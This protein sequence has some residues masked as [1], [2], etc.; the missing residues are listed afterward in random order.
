MKNILSILIV[1]GFSLA[2]CEDL[3]SEKILSETQL[4]GINHQLTFVAEVSDG[5]IFQHTKNFYANEKRDTNRRCEDPIA[6]KV[7]LLKTDFEGNSISEKELPTMLYQGSYFRKGNATF[8]YNNGTLIELDDFLNEKDK[9]TIDTKAITPEGFTFA[10][11]SVNNLAFRSKQDFSFVGVLEKYPNT[12][13]WVV[14]TIKN[15]VVT[16]SALSEDIPYWSGR[17]LSVMELPNGDLIFMTNFYDNKNQ[18]SLYYLYRY[19]AA[20]NEI[21]QEVILPT[22][23]YYEGT[24]FLSAD[25]SIMIFPSSSNQKGAYY[26]ILLYDHKTKELDKKALTTF[27]I[28]PNKYWNFTGNLQV[29]MLWQWED[30]RPLIYEIAADFSV[31]QYTSTLEDSRFFKAEHLGRWYFYTNEY[32]TQDNLETKLLW[33]TALH[34]N[35]SEKTLFK[36]VGYRNS[37]R[38]FD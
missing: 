12:L 17:V 7:Y 3:L 22:N 34:T 29:P 8:Y 16:S 27:K 4:P 36:G 24:L 23:T 19:N 18:Q 13:K 32:S 5:L 37:C 38:W 21:L 25:N 35:F 10:Y 31:K 20:K 33:A 9:I 26:E 11:S 15:G 1:L 6:S 28:E 14:A 2:S 30:K